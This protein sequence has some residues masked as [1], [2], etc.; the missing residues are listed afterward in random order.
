[1]NKAEILVPEPCGSE[2]IQVL[3]SAWFCR[4][5]KEHVTSSGLRTSPCICGCAITSGCS[6]L[7]SVREAV[8]R[9]V[10]LV[11]RRLVQLEVKG[12]KVENRV[13]VS[14]VSNFCVGPDVNE[15]ASSS[16]RGSDCDAWWFW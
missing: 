6:A 14:G 7:E 5:S 16:R 11:L 1:M 15:A 2:S 4:A 8:G 10:K 13:L 9:R 12:D 3:I